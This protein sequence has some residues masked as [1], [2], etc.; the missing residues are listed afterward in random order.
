MNQSNSSLAS[1]LSRAPSHLARALT[2]LDEKSEKAVRHKN[3]LMAC[4]HFTSYLAGILLAEYRAIDLPVGKH[5]GVKKSPIRKTETKIKE[6][7]LQRKLSWGSYLGLAEQAGLA[8]TEQKKNL[9]ILQEWVRMDDSPERPE[10]KDFIEEYKKIYSETFEKSSKDLPLKKGNLMTFLNAVL[11]LRNKEAHPEVEGKIW[12]FTEDYLNS[13]SPLLDAALHALVEELESVWLYEPWELIEEKGGDWILRSLDN[14]TEKTVTGKPGFKPSAGS[15]VL[16]D[17][18]STEAYLS[19]DFSGNLRSHPEAEEYF[20][21][22]AEKLN[23]AG[24][25]K[26]LKEIIKEML[27]DEQIDLPERRELEAIASRNLKMNAERLE[28]LVLEA[29]KSM[30]IEGNPFVENDPLFEELLDDSLRSGD[31]D[32]L[33]LQARAEAH[34]IKGSQFQIL[35]NERASA[36]SVDLTQLRSSERMTL[37]QEDLED[38]RIL[39]ETCFWIRD[40]HRLNQELA[41]DKKSLY[42][43]V[44]GQADE[45]PQSREGKHKRLWGEIHQVLTRRFCKQEGWKPWVAAWNQ[46]R[47]TGTLWAR[48]EYEGK[49]SGRKKWLRG[50]ELHVIL[51][52]KHHVKGKE[53]L[54][55]ER[56]WGFLRVGVGCTDT[57]MP[58]GDIYAKELGDA[59]K[60]GKGRLDYPLFERVVDSN[61]KSFI[62]EYRDALLDKKDLCLF[63]HSVGGKGVGHPKPRDELVSVVEAMGDSDD[64]LNDYFLHNPGLKTLRFINQWPLLKKNPARVLRNLDLSYELLAGMLTKIIRDYEWA[65]RTNQYQPKGFF[66]G[67][68]GD[69][70]ILLDGTEEIF[71]ATTRKKIAKDRPDF[72]RGTRYVDYLHKNR[73]IDR[74][75]NELV[76]GFWQG[77]EDDHFFCGFDAR[78]SARSRPL[79]TEEKEDHTELLR[80]FFDAHPGIGLYHAPG[81]VSFRRRISR[82]ETGKVENPDALQ[83]EWNAA[84]DAMKKLFAFD[85]GAFLKNSAF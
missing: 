71:P 50:D 19:M 72:G 1:I 3:L 32:E 74:G 65:Y 68:T 29:S 56:D 59:K 12:P 55:P 62:R 82:D 76:Y 35:L 49:R 31:F 52:A 73:L 11:M 78:T 58:G 81:Q 34:G 6:L 15:L 8:L 77:E 45:N 60:G 53:A 33:L 25:E 46:G 2:H 67:L 43:V 40:L 63:T 23:Q 9:S 21:A 18:E 75:L 39:S 20:E 37:T 54:D 64:D 24:S 5:M 80:R 10:W 26:D 57:L 4:E 16:L 48:L 17:L 84:I 66:H 79:T 28:A 61:I 47:M 14:G 85:D 83:A 51:W 70:K 38:A 44:K 13:V 69:F 7:L 27:G 42:E 41:E 36:L 22:Q 30:G